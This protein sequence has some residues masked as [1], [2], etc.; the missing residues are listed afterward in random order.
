MT[1]IN[2]SCLEPTRHLHQD[3]HF[4]HQTSV[5]MSMPVDAISTR[6]YHMADVKNINNTAVKFHKSR[7]TPTC[8]SP[9]SGLDLFDTISKKSEETKQVSDSSCIEFTDVNITLVKAGD[10]KPMEQKRVHPEKDQLKQGSGS[11]LSGET[12]QNDIEPIASKVST[13]PPFRM[14][15]TQSGVTQ[16]FL[17]NFS[18]VVKQSLKRS[19]RLR[20]NIKGLMSSIE[21][22]IGVSGKSGGGPKETVIR[23]LRRIL[24]TQRQQFSHR[25]KKLSGLPYFRE[26]EGTSS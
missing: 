5:Q 22:D 14:V 11:E 3:D 13:P 26:N 8:T 19:R 18:E 1:V 10:I 25:T 23:A 9:T 12:S 17:S 24:V 6:G 4:D 20:S 21:K 16:G 2:Q 7:I 15:D